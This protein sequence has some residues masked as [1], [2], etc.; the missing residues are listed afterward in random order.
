MIVGL[1]ILRSPG[2]RGYSRL[3]VRANRAGLN[4][5]W[6]LEC[7]IESKAEVAGSIPQQGRR[8]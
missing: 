1:G 2:V 3:I 5:R 6:A 8:A 7:Q 4:V